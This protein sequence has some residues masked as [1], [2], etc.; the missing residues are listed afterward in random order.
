[1]RVLPPDRR[2][3]LRL[4]GGATGAVFTGQWCPGAL[5]GSDVV[6]L[7]IL[8][9][10]DLH[11]HILPTFDYNGRPDLGGLARCATQI[12]RWRAENPNSLLI[13][14]GDVY[15]GTQFALRDEGRMMIAL[16]N[17]L[18]YDAWIVGNH[19]FDWGIEP[20]FHALAASK[21]PVLAA[22]M[23]LGGKVAG[24]FNQHG[25]PFTRIQPFLFREIAGVKLSLIGLTTPG[26]PFWFPAKFIGGL[27]FSDPV[28]AARRVVRQVKSLGAEIIL[29]A[30]HMGLKERAGGDDFANRSMSLTA[31]FPEAAVFIAGHTHQA[32]ESQLTNGVVLTQADHYGIHAGRI[33]LY[34]DRGR[35]RLL[36]QETRT[37][38]M[39]GSIA[40]DPVVLS[41]AQPQL[42]EADRILSEQVGELVD[43]LAAS[44]PPGEASAV[45]LLIAA[46]IREAL[47]ERGLTVDGVFHGLF[48]EHTLQTGQKTIGDLWAILP[49]ENFLVTAEL[50]PVG[51]RV[52]MEEVFESRETRS[53]AGFRFTLAG[54]R[55]HRRLTTLVRADGKPLERGHRYR[56]AFNTFDASS[57]GHRF[58]KLREMLTRPEANCTFHPV[59]SREALIGYFRR[60]KVVRRSMLDQDWK[61]AG[62]KEQAF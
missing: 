22:N 55:N 40:L 15:Q 16:F 49:Y 27:E 50:D 28:M 44:A 9:T 29:L 30:G 57:G 41:R 51:L 34:F 53:L 52:M 48:E 47:A 2:A 1:M 36:H 20:F 38:L 61:G 43:P 19:E 39:D 11:G 12:A 59:Q 56:I 37:V 54:E 58:M 21:M 6:R 25:H 17:L 46:A 8:H 7:S 45:I 32:I 24:N 31:E 13:D 35:R 26:M 14:I 5:A 62:G 42:E 33:D 10:T 18:G 60:R 3:F 4:L 23:A